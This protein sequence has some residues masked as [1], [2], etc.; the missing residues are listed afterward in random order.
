MSAPRNTVR[1]ALVGQALEEIDGVIVR[2]ET[3]VASVS[4]CEEGLKATTQA[5]LDASDKYQAAVNSA[6]DQAKSEL[7]EFIKRQAVLGKEQHEAMMQKAAETAAET[8]FRNH[9][10]D[11]AKSLA[12][13]LSKTVEE[14]KKAGLSRM[15][16]N[17]IL[18]FTSSILTGA[19]V[20]FLMKA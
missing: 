9:A 17:A 5:L 1:E 16:E 10:S 2:I 4:T 18:A 13:V 14:F 3:L 15:A 8:A 19:V 20:F 12:Q 7:A 11:Q 6:T